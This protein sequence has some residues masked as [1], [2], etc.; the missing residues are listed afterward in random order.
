MLNVFIGYDPR[1]EKAFRVAEASLKAKASIPV[2]V[3]PIKEWECRKHGYTRP[4]MVAQSGQMIDGVDAKPFST[5]FSFTRFL[6]PH[7]MGYADEICLFTDADM[8]WRC[9]VAEVLELCTGDKAVWCV[10]HKHIPSET[11]RKSVV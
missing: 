11:D 2:R 7:L 9:D 10:Q 4:Y 3:F 6:V 1:D 8:L 5:G